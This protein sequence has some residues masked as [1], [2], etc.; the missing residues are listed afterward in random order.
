MITR[1]AT[2]HFSLQV[3]TKSRYFWRL[4]KKRKLRSVSLGAAGR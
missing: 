3:V 1:S 4:S 2:T